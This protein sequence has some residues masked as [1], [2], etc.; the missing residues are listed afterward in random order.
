M[1]MG[2][3]R[4]RRSARSIMPQSC[5]APARSHAHARR[6]RR[7][8]R[9][10]LALGTQPLRAAGLDHAGGAVRR[11][12][13]IQTQRVKLGATLLRQPKVEVCCRPVYLV[14]QPGRSAERH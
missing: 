8:L 4:P 9:Q 5:P 13:L 6:L 2:I 10:G 7:L 14:A 11:D 1:R 12:Q 3:A